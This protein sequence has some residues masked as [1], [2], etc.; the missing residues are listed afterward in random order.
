MGLEYAIIGAIAGGVTS[1]IMLQKRKGR[2]AGFLHA[3]KQEGAPG[4]RQYLDK[5]IR[6]SAALSAGQI[7]DQRERM[8]ALAILGDVEALERE[9]AQH[10]GGLNVVTQVDAVALVGIAVRSAD[11]A[12]AARRLDEIAAR[13]EREGGVLMGL[14]KKKTRALATLVQFMAG[15]QVPLAQAR[16]DIESF[17]G[18][19]GMT[20]VL[21]WQAL[22]MALGRNGPN[23]GSEELRRK[24][25]DFTDA[26][27]APP[28]DGSVR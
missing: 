27:D 5:N 22:A 23:Q 26:F 11:P 19:G 9:M 14:V 4:A 21:M 15:Q 3:L 12:D 20:G 16:P 6:A 18:D 17:A 8:A 28:T 2:R 13:M 24:V 25:R 1:L 10:R 7:I